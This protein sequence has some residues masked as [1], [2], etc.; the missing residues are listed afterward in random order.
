MYIGARS[1][2]RAKAS[3]KRIEEENTSPGNGKAMYWHIDLIDPQGVKKSAEEFVKKEQRLDVL[4][5]FWIF[6]LDFSIG[7]TCASI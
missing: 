7:F 6:V 4:S 5:T 2:E 3:I 1:E